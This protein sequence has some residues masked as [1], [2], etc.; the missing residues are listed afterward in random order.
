MVIQSPGT[1]YSGAYEWRSANADGITARSQ[2]F[3]KY[4]KSE[5]IKNEILILLC[6]DINTLHMIHFQRCSEVS[7]NDDPVGAHKLEHRL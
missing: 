5:K 4:K 7:G 3:M 6:T 2:L 1:G